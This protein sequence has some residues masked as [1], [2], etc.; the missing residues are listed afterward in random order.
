MRV[1]LS[2][3]VELRNF[4]EAGEVLVVPV[5]HFEEKLSR[6]GVGMNELS[7]ESPVLM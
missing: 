2:D 5:R 6:V 4:R 3:L 1:S 7:K